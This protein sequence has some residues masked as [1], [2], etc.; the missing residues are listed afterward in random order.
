[1]KEGITATGASL[2]FNGSYGGSSISYGSRSSIS[3]TRSSISTMMGEMVVPRTMTRTAS[4]ALSRRAVSA[5]PAAPNANVLLPA[6]TVETLVQRQKDSLLRTIKECRRAEEKR[7]VRFERATSASERGV[8]ET[9]FDME[10]S[11]DQERLRRLTTDFNLVRRAISAGDINASVCASRREMA[12][13]KV[14]PKLQLDHNRFAGAETYADLVKHEGAIKMFER[15]DRQAERK[16][17]P[18]YDPYPV[19]KNLKL[20]QQKR[21]VLQQLVKIEMRALNAQSAPGIPASAGGGARR[22]GPASMY[23]DSSSRSTAS[24]ATF[25]SGTSGRGA[26]AAIAGAAR[27]RHVV[28]PLRLPGKQPT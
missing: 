26:Q 1:M 13:K 27:S 28:P 15:I 19:Q 9:R 7:S 6:D 18:K 16:R 14:L 22:A 11:Q 8:L 3:T 24:Y 12:T 4:T 2:E 20:L 23:S 21:S 10:R 17:L 5:P 25:G